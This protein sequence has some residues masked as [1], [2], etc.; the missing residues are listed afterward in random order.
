M[1]QFKTQNPARIPEIPYLDPILDHGSILSQPD[2]T[3]IVTFTIIF[4][5][6]L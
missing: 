3:T 2:A 1:A 5:L 6:T 4:L